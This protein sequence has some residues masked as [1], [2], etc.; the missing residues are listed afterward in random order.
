MYQSDGNTMLKELKE[1]MEVLNLH[2]EFV[3]DGL[4]T[5]QEMDRN[6]YDILKFYF[7]NIKRKKL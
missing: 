5:E 2:V 7:I 1:L 3:R 6:V 4:E